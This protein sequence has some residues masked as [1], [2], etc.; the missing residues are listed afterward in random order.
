M[1][2]DRIFLLLAAFAGLGSLFLPFFNNDYLLDQKMQVSAYNY[3]QVIAD[4]T[5]AIPYEESNGFWN[6]TWN[7]T[8]SIQEPLDYAT[9]GGVFLVLALPVI[10]LLFFLGYIIKALRGKQYANGIFLTLLSL[11]IAWASFH[12]LSPTSAQALFG[13]E[14]ETPLNFFSIAGTGFWLAFGSM[15]AAAFSL[16]F[17]KNLE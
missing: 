3:G 15:V 6:S 1:K 14:I 5:G 8:K 11:G 4:A 7:L 16:F 12:F 9:V 13:T 17:S 2:L 10:F